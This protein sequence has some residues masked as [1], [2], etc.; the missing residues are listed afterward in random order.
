MNYKKFLKIKLCLMGNIRNY[1]G[2]RA[3]G[4]FSTS[5]HHGLRWSEGQPGTDVIAIFETGVELNTMLPHG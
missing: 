5:S 1:C 2:P 4:L 3:H